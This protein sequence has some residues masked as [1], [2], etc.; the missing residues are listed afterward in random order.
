MKKNYM[1]TF[2]VAALVAVSSIALNSCTKVIEIELNEADRQYV[3]EGL[4]YEGADSIEVR[5]TKTTSFFDTT[6]P[7]AVNDAVVKVTMPDASVVTL[8]AMGNGYYKADGLVIT[9]EATYQ[10]QVDVAEKTFTASSYMPASVALDSLE[11]EFSEGIFGGD[12]FYDVFLLFEDAIGLNYY[13]ARAWVNGEYLNEPGEIQVFDDNLNDGNYIR[14]PIWVYQ[15]E[16]GDSVEVEL[17]SL[18]PETYEFY[19]TFALVA[20]EDAG[21]PFTAA[22]A[23]PDTN[24]K[25]GALGVFAAIATSRGVIEV[26]E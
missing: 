26:P 18:S 10:L 3:I 21:S 20:S 6:G 17:Q 8:N 9:N 14:I 25:G 4:V 5:V 13:R 15:F 22:P 19:Q 7:E 2:L 1:Q 11:Y 16:A 24:I 23:N 12:D